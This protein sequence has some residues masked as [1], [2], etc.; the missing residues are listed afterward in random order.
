M[1]EKLETLA[2]DLSTDEADLKAAREIRAHEAADFAANEKEL[3]EVVDTLQRAISILEKEMAKTGGASMMQL[4][5]ADNIAQVLST[6][7]QGTGISSE[8][9]ARLT[10]LVQSRASQNEEDAGAPA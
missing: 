8:S 9:E 3:S 7:V 4:H 6:V 5:N 10:A 1:G 2:A